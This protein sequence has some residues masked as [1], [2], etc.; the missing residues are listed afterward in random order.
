MEMRAQNQQQINPNLNTTAQLVHAVS[1]FYGR[2]RSA[3][4]QQTRMDFTRYPMVPRYYQYTSICTNC[5]QRWCH[6]HRQICPANE[7]SVII[8]VLPGSLQGSVESR[9]TAT[10]TNESDR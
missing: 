8:V 9:K 4:Y 3:N 5:G 6:N 7:K 10:S 1:K 2:N